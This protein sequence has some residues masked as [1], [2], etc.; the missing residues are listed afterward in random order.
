[1]LF[2]PE[3]ILY[4]KGIC[5]FNQVPAGKIIRFQPPSIQSS[6]STELLLGDFNKLTSG[7]IGNCST[8]DPTS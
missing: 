7:D 1:M 2:L 8:G 6:S 4:R 5:R 3:L